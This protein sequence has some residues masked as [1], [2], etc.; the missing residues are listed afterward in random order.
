MADP[1]NPNWGVQLSLTFTSS[2]R[3]KIS[4]GVN[5]DHRLGSFAM[6]SGFGVSYYSN[7]MGTRVSGIETRISAMAGFNNG[8]TSAYMGT[9]QWLGIGKMK[10]FDQRTGIFTFKA[11]DFR[12]AY[13]NDGAPPFVFGKFNLFA[14]GDDSYRTAAAAIGYKDLVLKTNMFTGKRDS[15]KE[16]VKYSNW[17]DLVKNNKVKIKNRTLTQNDIDEMIKEKERLMKNRPVT[18]TGIPSLEEVYKKG[19][20]SLTSLKG[21]YGEIYTNILTLEE[22]SIKRYRHSTLTLGY[23]GI[24]AG[25]ESE[26]VRHLFQNRLA[27]DK[28]G[29]QPQWE[30]L[31]NA[32]YPYAAVTPFKYNYQ[33]NYYNFGWGNSFSLW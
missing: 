24:E 10:E 33:S 23:H 17:K 4:G 32:V 28:I 13:E 11:G 30:M 1:R 18:S 15:E 14:G 6:A 7:F 5:V 12:L 21:Q 26:K 16:S 3:F 20:R 29:L 22:D 31:S 25:I 2:G 19:I 8:S 27:H 9:N